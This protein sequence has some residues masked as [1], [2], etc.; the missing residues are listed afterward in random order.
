MIKKYFKLL[1]GLSIQK[2]AYFRFKKLTKMLSL[3]CDINDVN[4]TSGSNTVD[5]Q[6]TSGRIKKEEL[7]DESETVN[8]STWLSITSS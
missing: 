2:N 3:Q 6:V 5:D 1:L 8:K 7:R 4:Q